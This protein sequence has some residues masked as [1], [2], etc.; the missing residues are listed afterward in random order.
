[1]GVWA[2]M[3]GEIFWHSLMQNGLY[4]KATEKYGA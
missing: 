1:M 4:R 3:R 2:R